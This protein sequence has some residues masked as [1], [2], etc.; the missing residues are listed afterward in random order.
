MFG[1]YQNIMIFCEGQIKVM[2][3]C[4]QNKIK[5]WDTLIIKMN[6]DLQEGVT[7]KYIIY[8]I[9]FTYPQNIYATTCECI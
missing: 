3:H 7:I 4:K 8:T 9:T 1:E 5:L 6:I 2:F